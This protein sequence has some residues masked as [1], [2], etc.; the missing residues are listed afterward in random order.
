MGLQLLTSKKINKKSAATTMTTLLVFISF[1]QPTYT[2][3]FSSPPELGAVERIEIAF[4]ESYLLGEVEMYYTIERRN[5]EYYSDSGQE[6]D[7]HLISN[8]TESL[9]D[10]YEAERYETDFCVT[11][12]YP[13][14]T[15]AVTYSDTEV[16]LKSNSNCHCYIPWNV[17][18][19][20]NLYVQYN[21]KIPSALFK[22]LVELDR[23]EWSHYDKEARW[24]CFSGEVPDIYAEKGSPLFPESKKA[25]HKGE[26]PVMWRKDVA[27]SI[28]GLPLYAE[29]K[30][31]VAVRK[32]MRCFDADTGKEIWSYD[33]VTSMKRPILNEKYFGLIGDNLLVTAEDGLLC[34]NADTGKKVWEVTVNVV[35]PPVF[36]NDRVFVRSD[37]TPEPY[38]VPQLIGITCLDSTTGRTLWEFTVEETEKCI[39]RYNQNMLLYEGRIYFGTGEP[40]LCCLDAESGS[41]IWKYQ[42]DVSPWL[43]LAGDNL[44]MIGEWGEGVVCLSRDTGEKM[45]EYTDMKFRAVYGDKILMGEYTPAPNSMLPGFTGE[46]GILVD[47]SSGEPVWAGDIFGGHFSNVYEDGVLYF[48]TDGKTVRALDVKT[49]KELFKY[50]YEGTV[51]DVKVFD[52]GILL[53]IANYEEKVRFVERLLFLNKDGQLLWEYQYK[54]IMY[55]G[56]DALLGY[57]VFV[58]RGEGFIEAFDAETGEHLWKTE[59][60]GS[61]IADAI[62]RG[63]NLYMTADDGRVYCLDVTGV[64]VWEVDTGSGLY[65]NN[66]KFEPHFFEITETA[67]FVYTEDGKICAISQADHSSMA[68]LLVIIVLVL[69][70]IILAVLAILIMKGRKTVK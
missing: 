66:N 36:F 19:K 33:S 56:V 15:V 58:F 60:R 22:I 45:W 23:K 54:D 68:T 67:L 7:S 6:I 69:V 63:N 4:K 42:E 38:T 8:L 62:I 46:Y 2:I 35:G 10:L 43:E 5:S 57:R 30:I 24:G 59:I 21:G 40:S 29:G 49:T 32:G 47:S 37:K 26:A 11:C 55:G 3:P 64:T 18:Y 70:G 25:D 13:E 50:T 1:L 16:I 28:V 12:I 34:L 61:K 41:I 44:L 65:G 20:G 52:Q 9:S 39:V 17:E 31:F 14:F 51:S 27:N 48:C 53:S